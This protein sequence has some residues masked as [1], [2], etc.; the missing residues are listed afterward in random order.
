MERWKKELQAY[1]RQIIIHWD[2]E[3]RRWV[4]CRKPEKY[5]LPYPMSHEGMKKAISDA[6]VNEIFVCQNDEARPMAPG[7]WILD[8]LRQ[9]D[10]RRINFRTYVR[11]MD[12]RNDRIRAKIKEDASDRMR[13]QIND[14]WSHIRDEIRGDTTFRKNTITKT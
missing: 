2:P 9:R 8:Y 10:T 7:I 11:E 12:E 4:V 6:V 1:D 5:G 14:N 3:R 13:Y